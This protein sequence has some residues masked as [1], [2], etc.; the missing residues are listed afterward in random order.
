MLTVQVSL[1]AQVRLAMGQSD[2]E[3][4]LPEGATVDDLSSHLR[5]HFPKIAPYLSSC[6]VAVGV[7]YASPSTALA[8]G[9]DIALIPPV[10]GG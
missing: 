1:F 2:I 10:Q 7:E 4:T 3:V 9:D 5:E 8:D 6:R